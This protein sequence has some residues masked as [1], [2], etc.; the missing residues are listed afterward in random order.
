MTDLT[1]QAR[2]LR[3]KIDAADGT[4]QVLA[5][6]VIAPQVKAGTLSDAEVAKRAALFP[7]WEPGLAVKVGDLLQWDG[8][9]VEVVQAHTT[10][11]DWQP[12]KVPAL[13]RVY[14]TPEMTEW[15]AGIAVKVGERFTYQGS[16]YEVL[17]AH[18]TQAGW[19]PSGVPSLW[20]KV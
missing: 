9:I 20:R 12:D 8:T 15:R 10:Q 2:A 13:F 14:R 5:D 3:A 11:A 17:Q 16:T 4:R 18:T 6:A 7:K 19:T 1:E